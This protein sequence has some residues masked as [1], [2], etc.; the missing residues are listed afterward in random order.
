[1][2]VHSGRGF[3]DE[4]GVGIEWYSGLSRVTRLDESRELPYTP[5]AQRTR[6]IESEAWPEALQQE[7]LQRGREWLDAALDE[8]RADRASLDGLARRELHLG[9]LTSVRRDDLLIPLLRGVVNSTHQESLDQR[10]ED[11]ASEIEKE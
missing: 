3:V 1:M 6:L 7:C 4:P 10:Y 9:F 11:L 2:R 5:A 8:I